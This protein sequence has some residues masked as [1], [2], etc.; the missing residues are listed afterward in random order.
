VR[1]LDRLPSIKLKL[2]AVILASVA[3]SAL[4]S[5]IGFRLGLEIWLRPI[6]AAVLSLALVQ[7]LSRGMTSPLRDMARAAEDMAAGRPTS[8]IRATSSDEVG[9]LA[10]AFNAMTAQLAEVDRQRR[11]LVANVSHELRTPIGALRAMLEN[12]VD[13]VGPPPDPETLRTMLGQVER[14]SRLIGQLL[15]LSRLESGAVPL[16]RER[17]ALDEL[18]AR[19]VAE[20]Q[21]HAGSPAVALHVDGGAT[22]FGDPERV[23]QVVANLLENAVRHSP[24]GGCIDVRVERADHEVRVTVDDEGPGIPEPER[25]R[26]FERFYRADASRTSSGGG[27]G[28]GLAIARWIVDLHGGRIQAEARTPRGCRVTFTIPDEQEEHR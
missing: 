18:L 27:A 16:H 17:F 22:A 1:P 10:H 14:L 21:L 2:G 26:V 28:L 9:Q 5:T 23:H 15:D 24:P 20:C 3:V 13:G 8:P 25:E 7:L 4:V 11:D 12:L 19:S 6:V